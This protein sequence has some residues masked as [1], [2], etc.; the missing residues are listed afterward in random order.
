LQELA[1][2]PKFSTAVQR[3]KHQGEFVPRVEQ[4]VE[5]A[6]GNAASAAVF[7]DTRQRRKVRRPMWVNIPGK[8]STV[9]AC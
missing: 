6:A 5:V 8:F 9:L 7:K 4:A 3:M 1:A 2:E